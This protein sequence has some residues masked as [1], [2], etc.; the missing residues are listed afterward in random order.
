[1]L[2]VHERRRADDSLLAMKNA[3]HVKQQITSLRFSNYFN[4][5]QEITKKK[6]VKKKREKS[7]KEKRKILKRQEEEKRNGKHQ[8]DVRSSDSVS[9]HLQNTN[10]KRANEQRKKRMD[11]Q[12]PWMIWRNNSFSRM[13]SNLIFPFVNRLF[14]IIIFFSSFSLHFFVFVWR[15][16]ERVNVCECVHLQKSRFSSNAHVR[17]TILFSDSLQ[18][19]CVVSHWF[20]HKILLFRIVV[21]RRRSA[22]FNFWLRQMRTINHNLFLTVEKWCKFS[23]IK[24]IFGSLAFTP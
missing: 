17:L 12:W 13:K 20:N 2:S 22:T 1:M 24:K 15:G 23:I 16:R 11:E 4:A 10:S 3:R 5:K 9:F 14:F 18:P 7:W 19:W 21:C 8:S 6:K